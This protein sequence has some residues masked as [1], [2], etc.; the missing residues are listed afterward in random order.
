MGR[1]EQRKLGI[2]G[3]RQG[4]GAPGTGHLRGRALL[5]SLQALSLHLPT[6]RRRTLPPASPPLKAA[7]GKQEPLSFVHAPAEATGLP[8]G[9]FDLVSMCLVAHELPQSATR[10]I[11]REM[12]R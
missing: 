5:P 10:A 9:S 2:E 8:A 4:W 12:Y 6:P 7:A 1:R 11:M 3:W